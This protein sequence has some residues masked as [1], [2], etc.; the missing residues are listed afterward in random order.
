MT[1]ENIHSLSGVNHIEAAEGSTHEVIPHVRFVALVECGVELAEKLVVEGPVVIG[2]VACQPFPA[3]EHVRVLRARVRPGI[4]GHHGAQCMPP[5]CILLVWPA[6][7]IGVVD[8][9]TRQIE[10]PSL[11]GGDPHFDSLFRPVSGV[12]AH[13]LDSIHAGFIPARDIDVLM[14]HF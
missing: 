7:V 2:F 13:D 10:M 3:P 11:V 1:M 4:A 8:A 6:A 9:I 12:F 5:V 14:S